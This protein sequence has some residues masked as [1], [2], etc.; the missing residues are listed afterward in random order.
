MRLSVF[1]QVNNN[2]QNPDEKSK[3]IKII[4]GATACTWQHVNF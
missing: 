3:K 2:R 4:K 1:I